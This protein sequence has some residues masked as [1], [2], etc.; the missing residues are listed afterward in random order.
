MEQYDKLF[1]LL[2]PRGPQYIV[3]IYKAYAMCFTCTFIL[4]NIELNTGTTIFTLDK[5]ENN[6]TVIQSYKCVTVTNVYL[7][8]AVSYITSVIHTSVWDNDNC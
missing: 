8:Y 6:A 3:E 1:V 7:V 2:S 4:F 5:P